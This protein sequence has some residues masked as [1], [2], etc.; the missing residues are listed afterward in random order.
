MERARQIATQLGKIYNIS[1]KVRIELDWNYNDE[2]VYRLSFA[3][4]FMGARLD[5]A[6]E[7]LSVDVD[8]DKTLQKLVLEATSQVQSQI[9]FLLV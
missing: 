6:V 8:F 5:V 2:Y 1:D 9:T 7:L 3:L 4:H